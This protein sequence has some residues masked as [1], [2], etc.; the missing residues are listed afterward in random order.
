MSATRL[1][2]AAPERLSWLRAYCPVG[3]LGG[4][5]LLYRFDAAPVD[6]PGPTA[7]APFC[8]GDVSTRTG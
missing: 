8:D 5:V 1:T 3:T 4:S 7:P 6:G 2:S